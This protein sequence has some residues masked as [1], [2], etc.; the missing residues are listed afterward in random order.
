MWTH[1]ADDIPKR[2][3][4]GNHAHECWC[5]PNITKEQRDRLIRKVFAVFVHDIFICHII[6]VCGMRTVVAI[7]RRHNDIFVLNTLCRE[8]VAQVATSMRDVTTFTDD[9]TRKV[10]WVLYEMK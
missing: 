9:L 1:S 2:V 3:T 8:P 7:K 10:M 5:V 6:K 4:S